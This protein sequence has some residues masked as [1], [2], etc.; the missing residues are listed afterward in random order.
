MTRRTERE[1]TVAGD[2]ILR[3]VRGVADGTQELLRATAHFSGECLP[4]ARA[5]VEEQLE[6]LREALGDAGEYAR[7]KTRDAAHAVDQHVHRSPWQAI[8]IAMGVGVLLGWLSGR[9]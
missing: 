3:N 2:R 9:R 7:E 8:G 4:A 5:H 6:E 1:M